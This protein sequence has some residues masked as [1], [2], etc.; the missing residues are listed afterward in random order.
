VKFGSINAFLTHLARVAATLPEAQRH[1]EEAAGAGLAHHA[2]ALIGA[3]A[4]NWPGLADSTIAQKTARGQVGRISPTDPLYAKGDLRESISFQADT[5]GLVLG[6]TDPVA[7][8]HEHGT[9]RMPPRPFIGPT[10]FVHGHAAADL[11]AGYVVGAFA[12]R[13]RPI[14]DHRT[15]LPPGKA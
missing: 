12:G 5:H 4:E 2:Q 10:M 9:S 14:G 15:A 8:F 1:G 13:T 6:S 3:E 7:P 11:I